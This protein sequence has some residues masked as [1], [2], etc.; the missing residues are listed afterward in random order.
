MLAPLLTNRHRGIRRT[1]SLLDIRFTTLQ[2][3][4]TQAIDN[5]AKEKKFEEWILGFL[6]PRTSPEEYLRRHEAWVKSIHETGV[7][8]SDERSDFIRRTD[9]RSVQAHSRLMHGRWPPSHALWLNVS[10]DVSNAVRFTADKTLEN[11]AKPPEEV[12]TDAAVLVR[13]AIDRLVAQNVMRG[14]VGSFQLSSYE[15]VKR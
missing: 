7:P 15:A 4:L 8:E 13:L 9:F 11:F 2:A 5:V 3:R 6:V 10:Q 1:F 12:E 14:T